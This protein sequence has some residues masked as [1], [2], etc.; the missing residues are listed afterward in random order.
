M[1]ILIAAFV[2]AFSISPAFAQNAA[3]PC[4]YGIIMPQPMNIGLLG[5]VKAPFTGILEVNSE[6]Q[7]YDGTLLQSTY[8]VQQARDSA[9]RTHTET[10]ETCDRDRDENNHLVKMITVR[11]PIARTSLSWEYGRTEGGVATLFH[12]STSA[13]TPATPPAQPLF[14]PWGSSKR[15]VQTQGLGSKNI[16]GVLAEGTRTTVIIP[17]G[18]EGNSQP[19]TVVDDRWF[20]KELKVLVASTHNDPRS[21][22]TSLMSDSVIFQEMRKVSY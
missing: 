10:A 17:A 2:F 1:R 8:T 13:A 21:G 18:E 22:I 20:S 3:Q 12:R 19:I 15:T 14:Q 4:T 11:D 7:L 5:D 9:G 16:A 6:E